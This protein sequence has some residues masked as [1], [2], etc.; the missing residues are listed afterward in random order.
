MLDHNSQGPNG[1]PRAAENPFAIPFPSRS[2]PRPQYHGLYES[3]RGNYERPETPPDRIGRNGG[4]P[5][6]D[7]HMANGASASPSL[8]NLLH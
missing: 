2:P 4:W 8:R 3:P 5:T 1:V 7:G 6:S